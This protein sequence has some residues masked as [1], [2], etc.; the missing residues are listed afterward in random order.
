MPGIGSVNREI[1]VKFQK[2]QKASTNLLSKKTNARVLS[3]NNRFFM[4][5]FQGRFIIGVVVKRDNIISSKL[6]LIGLYFFPE[7]HY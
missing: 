2:C 5:S 1:A 7:V 6:E 4:A 3:V